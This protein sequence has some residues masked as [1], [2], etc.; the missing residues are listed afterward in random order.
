MPRLALFDLDRTVI[1]VNSATGWIKREVRL[2]Y[3][4]RRHAVR[5][6]WEIGKYQM[7]WSRMEQAIEDAVRMLAGEEEAALM[8]RT[9]DFWQEE[10]AG[11]IR[12]GAAAAI[13]A[14]ADAG[15]HVV[16]LTSS[17]NYMCQAVSGAL[18]FVDWG[19]NRFEVVDARF[20]GEVVRPL[21]YAEGKVAHAQRMAEDSGLPL[22]EA[23]FYTDSYSDL[24]ALEAVGE[25]VVVHPDPRLA[26][27]ARKRGWRIEDW[28]G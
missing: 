23:V 11:T 12:P 2:G 26:R 16:L 6:A 15:D 8:A 7:G 9:M 10:V 1:S 5:G 20:T 3:L 22:E 13:R 25:P 24:A 19:C 21:C 17:S 14:H 28:G 27:H 4:K 18:P